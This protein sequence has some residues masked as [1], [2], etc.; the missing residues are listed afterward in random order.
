MS[1]NVKDI[2]SFKLL[3]VAGAY[4]RGDEKNKMLTRIYGTCFSTQ[5]ELDEYLWQQ[6]EAKKR[7]HRVLGKKTRPFYV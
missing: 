6:K 4:W 3:S 2:G 7:D 5:K 1:K